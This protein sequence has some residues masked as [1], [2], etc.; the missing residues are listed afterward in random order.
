MPVTRLP[1]PG[2]FIV[3]SFAVMRRRLGEALGGPALAEAAHED[4]LID[5]PRRGAARGRLGHREQRLQE[6]PSLVVCSSPAPR[7]DWA[8]SS[9][10][11]VKALHQWLRMNQTAA[12]M[13]AANKVTMASR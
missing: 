9:R 1:V 7:K 3:G 10:Q 2:A 4:P 8:P 12:K 5:C 11:Q 6:Q 13:E